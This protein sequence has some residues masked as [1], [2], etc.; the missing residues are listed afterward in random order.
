[1]P[2]ALCRQPSNSASISACEVCGARVCGPPE[3]C[4]PNHMI[5]RDILVDD[6]QELA[7]TPSSKRVHFGSTEVRMF[8][9]IP[10]TADLVRAVSK[11]PACRSHKAASDPMHTRIEVSVARHIWNPRTGIVQDVGIGQQQTRRIT[12]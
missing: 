7:L 8:P 2:R 9:T 12:H 3:V 11:C 6:D 1:M 4:Y 5:L 10:S